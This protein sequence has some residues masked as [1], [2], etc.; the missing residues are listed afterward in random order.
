ILLALAIDLAA[1]DP[2]GR[3][4]PVAWIGALLDRG[5]RALA[6][7][8]PP[9]L[10]ARGA[11]L[12]VGVTALAAAAGWAIAAA[13][14]RAGAAGVV[15]EAL[16]LKSVLALR[17]LAA[18]GGEV[19]G[20]L[21]GGDLAAARA[22]VG[23]HLVS[24]PTAGLDGPAVA[25][26]AVESVAENLTDALAAPLFFFVLLGLPGAAAYRAVNTADAMIGYRDGR[27]EHFGKAAARLDDLLNLA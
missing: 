13:A 15:L 9:R 27:L 17:G 7:G 12:V 16:A 20:H 21:E 26:A 6:G 18:A 23:R 11:L 3:W 2:P 14:A 24:R 19:A 1:G 5:T 4:H 25:S 22:A 8:S 10:L